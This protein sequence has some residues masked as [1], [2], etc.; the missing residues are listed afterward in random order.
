MIGKAMYLAPRKTGFIG[1]V[2]R[3]ICNLYSDFVQ[4]DNTLL[5]YLLT[6]TFFKDHIELFFAA[7]RSR[8]GFNKNLTA[9][10]IMDAY[11]RLLTR[12]NIKVLWLA[13]VFLWITCTL[14]VPT[15]SAINIFIYLYIYKLVYIILG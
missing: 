7:V 15:T 2:T 10:Q 13:I 8:G 4:I 9:G 12:H 14:K 1:F 6:H 3:S 5:K 11:K